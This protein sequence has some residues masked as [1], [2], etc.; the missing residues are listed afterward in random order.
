MLSRRAV[1]EPTLQIE[2]AYRPEIFFSRVRWVLFLAGQGA[3]GGV[4][5]GQGALGAVFGR[6]GCAGRCFWGAR[7]GATGATSPTGST[8]YS[9]GY[10]REAV[11]PAGGTECRFCAGFLGF[12]S[13]GH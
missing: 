10:G 3:L 11:W 2:L 8:R 9:P 5:A 1:T 13:C 4:F 6:P 7:G 12:L